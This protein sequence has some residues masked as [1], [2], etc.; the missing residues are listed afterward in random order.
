MK[1]Q[2]SIERLKDHIAL[3]RRQEIEA[4]RLIK[5]IES[6]LKKETAVGTANTFALEKILQNAREQRENIR[7]RRELLEN[8]VEK[9][10]HLRIT[11]RELLEDAM[12]E[13]NSFEAPI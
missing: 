11:T 1:V 6:W 4:D 13:A 7:R 5:C 12:Y 10:E 9:F 8:M 2:Y 3:V